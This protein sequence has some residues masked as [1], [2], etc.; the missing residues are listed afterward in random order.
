M[1]FY[2]T[3]SGLETFD[4]CR[5]YGLAQLLQVLAGGNGAPRIV[6]SGGTFLITMSVRPER[7]DFK[8]SDQW[9]ALFASDN[10]QRVFL[11][12]KAAW[13]E[14]SGR[15]KKSLQKSA[16]QV[17]DEAEKNGLPVTFG[18]GFALPGPLDP[19]GFKGLKGLTGGSYS[20]GQTEVD[21]FNWA[22]GCLGA[23]VAQRYKIQKAQGNKWEY[24]VSVPVPSEVRFSNF[25]KIRELVYNS[26]LKYTGVRNAAAHFTVL[27]ADAVRALAA[28]NPA[29][30]VRFSNL[31]YFSLFQS[32]QQFKPS[33]GGVANLGVL[34]DMALQRP[35]ETGAMFDT[36]NYLFRRGSAKGSEDLAEAITELV[37]VPSLETYY[38][39]ARIFN[40][41]VVDTNKGIKHENLY[42]PEALK[43]VMH[44]AES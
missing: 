40:R 33:R 42:T 12:Y 36:W 38:Q 9:V 28:G 29:F 17:I 20:E 18:A 13:K 41:Y 15:V 6:D 1:Q 10:W 14:Q 4:A 11:T 3:K 7:K 31:L 21:E 43:E 19:V 35:T 30:P 32:G 27:L 16:F 8:A 39:H 22:L 2:V 26:G 44:Y 25:Q 24:F 37:M 5:A 34:I 23:V